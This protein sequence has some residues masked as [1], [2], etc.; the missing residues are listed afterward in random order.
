M[1]TIVITDS[2]L[3]PVDWGTF[4]TTPQVQIL[5]LAL[6]IFTSLCVAATVILFKLLLKG[7]KEPEL[8]PVPRDILPTE[9]RI[10]DLKGFSE[11]PSIMID[12][13]LMPCRYF[14]NSPNGQPLIPS[15]INHQELPPYDKYKQ[16][17][18]YSIRPPVV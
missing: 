3:P 15:S 16:E 7:F 14:S 9:V 5:I 12:Q 8:A 10:D 2:K 1:D 6:I 17:P 11:R 13:K 4:F 18:P